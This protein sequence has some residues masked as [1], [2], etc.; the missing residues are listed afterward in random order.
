MAASVRTRRR[1]VSLFWKRMITNQLVYIA[2]YVHNTMRFIDASIEYGHYAFEYRTTY[3]E[4]CKICFIFDFV[5]CSLL[6]NVTLTDATYIL[7]YTYFA[8]WQMHLPLSWWWWK[9]FSSTLQRFFCFWLE[10]IFQL[11]LSHT[12]PPRFLFTSVLLFSFSYNSAAA[13]ENKTCI[14]FFFFCYVEERNGWETKVHQ[15]ANAW[16][17]RLRLSIGRGSQRLWFFCL[18]IPG[19]YLFKKRS[20]SAAKRTCIYIYCTS[21][22][23]KKWMA[24]QPAFPPP[25]ILYIYSIYIMSFAVHFSFSFS[26]LK[27]DMDMHRS[28]GYAD[29]HRPI[30]NNILL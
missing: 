21:T 27:V 28:P 18:Y 1:R 9:T 10:M 4:L 26:S 22:H 5:W 15:A 6:R 20:L 25:N 12:F 24:G 3:I 29:T 7:R 16:R 30:W 17:C 13:V 14:R 19:H 8:Y 23:T 11:N 2:C